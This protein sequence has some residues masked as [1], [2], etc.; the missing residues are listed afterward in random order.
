M[1][2]QPAP[3]ELAA[4][5]VL[6][7][8][9]NQHTPHKIS[10]IVVR[11][12]SAFTAVEDLHGCVWAC[13]IKGQK[14][15]YAEYHSMHET[16]FEQMPFKEC[17]VTSSHLQSLCL[18]LDGTVDAAAIDAHLLDEVLEYSS[19]MRTQLRI[20]GSFNATTMPPV[21]IST[22]VNALLRQ[23]VREALLSIHQDPFYAQRLEESSIERFLP[24][25]DEHYRVIRE[26]YRRE[27][28]DLFNDPEAKT[29][30]KRSATHAYA[31]Y[32]L[33]PRYYDWVRIHTGFM[34]EGLVRNELVVQKTRYYLFHGTHKKP[35][36]REVIYRAER[37]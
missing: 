22:Q 20:I 8:A 32:E 2:Q 17:V 12:N 33:S 26:R 15:S 16:F 11:K 29:H 9:R 34:P 5:P 7:T 23:R 19:K 10:D 6:R 1:S 37:Q 35:T 36:I 3:V 30:I 25:T 4:M 31:A 27:E 18:L 21:V 28:Q 14:P 13:C 24:V